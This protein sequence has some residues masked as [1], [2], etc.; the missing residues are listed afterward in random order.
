VTNINSYALPEL[1]GASR[2]GASSLPSVSFLGTSVPAA[3]PRA[4]VVDALPRV[5]GQVAVMV[6]QAQQVAVRT[7]LG[8]TNRHNYMTGVSAVGEGASDPPRDREPV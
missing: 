4:F 6:P 2:L 8:H 5:R 1:H 3:G 7:T